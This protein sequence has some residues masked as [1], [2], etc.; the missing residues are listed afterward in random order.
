MLARIEAIFSQAKNRRAFFQRIHHLYPA[1]DPCYQLIEK[2]YDTAKDEFRHIHRD[3]GERYFEHLRRST[4]IMIDWLFVTDWHLIVAELLHDLVEDIPSWTIERVRR[5]FGEE[6]ARLVD[7][8]TKPKDDEEDYFRRLP[9]APRSFWLMKLSD[10]LD[11]LLTLWGCTPEKINRKIK[12]TKDIF[13]VYARKELILAHEIEE[14]LE[15][16]EKR[17]ADGWCGQAAKEE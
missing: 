9:N 7:W 16:L 14:A 11:N 8:M 1:S 6:I 4:L 15:A 2:A 10:R 17:L 3:T 5:E 13:L 12:E